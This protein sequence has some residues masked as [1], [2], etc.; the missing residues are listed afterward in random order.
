MNRRGLSLLCLVVAVLLALYFRAKN[1]TPPQAV[2]TVIANPGATL[3]F[4]GESE[5]YLGPSLRHAFSPATLLHSPTS[6]PPSHPGPSSRRERA[7]TGVRR[8]E[9]ATPPPRGYPG[10]RRKTR[11][12]GGGRTNVSTSLHHAAASSFILAVYPAEL[13]SCL[14]WREL[15]DPWQSRVPNHDPHLNPRSRATGLS[16]PRPLRPGTR[17][18]NARRRERFPGGSR[19]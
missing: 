1:R 13:G 16:A 12:E 2:D 10:T 11:K 9:I 18:S 17:P 19:R 15:D 5:S 8:D 6:P 7:P 3:Y 4:A 14:P